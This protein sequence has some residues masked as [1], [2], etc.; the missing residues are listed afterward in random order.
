MQDDKPMRLNA[1]TTAYVRDLASIARYLHQKGYRVN[2]VSKLLSASVDFVM[3]HLIRDKSFTKFRLDSEA[4][5]YLI[6]SG[7]SIGKTERQRKAIVRG[8]QGES[9]ADNNDISL[10]YQPLKYE[11][12]QILGE[13]EEKKQEALKKLDE[14]LSQGGSDD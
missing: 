6:N 7:F 1:Q 11:N 5:D 10:G 2:E 8:L 4:Y 13:I 12:P 14:I 3:S 9:L